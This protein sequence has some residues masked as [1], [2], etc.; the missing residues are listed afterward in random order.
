M[1]WVKIFNSA[2][3]AREAIEEGKSRKVVIGDVRISLTRYKDAFYALQDH[4]PHSAAS[5]SQG[6]T[7]D[8]GELV[9]PLHNYCYDLKTGREMEQKTAD[10][11]VYEVKIEEEG[12]FINI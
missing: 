6:W 9:C 1:E 12:L 11:R 5:L 3:E 7:N 8:Y 10:A 2:E 4:C